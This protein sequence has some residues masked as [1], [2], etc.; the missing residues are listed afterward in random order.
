MRRIAPV[1]V[2][3]A[4]FYAVL[5][6]LRLDQHGAIW[7]AH[8]GDEFLHSA[9]TSHAIDSVHR[10]ESP[11]GYDGQFYFFIA[12]D[13][14]HAHDYMRVGTED[15]SGIRYARVAYPA[16]ARLASA[17]SM[18]VLPAVMIALNLLAVGLGTAAVALWLVRRGRTPWPAALYGLW[19]G[20][21]YAVFRDLSEPLAYCF[22]ALALLVFD[23]R[24]NRRLAGAAGFLALSLLT[25]ETT[26]A[27]VVGL[28]AAIALHDRSW[29]RPLAFF[30][31]AIAPMIAWR[32]A[33]TAWLHVTT[34]ESAHSGLKILLPFYGMYSR[35]PFDVQHK[36]IFYSVDLPLV[37]A[38]A[39]AL[40]LVYRRRELGLALLT[41]L[42][43]ALFVVFLPKNVT[44]D[45]GAVVR[46]A[47][48]ALLAALYLVP[49]IRSR[50][51]LAAGAF[52]LSPVWY[53]IVA[54]WLGVR[55]LRFATT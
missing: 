55:G 18:T 34:I 22:A 21:V 32:L 53:L 14:S 10:T 8:I 29:R 40:Y 1:L 20:V 49:A 19:P 39:G 51:V 16:A 5:V 6:P 27:F 38:G 15:Q 48:P 28:T 36:L 2:A 26:I 7:F 30:A 45:W 17:G 50:L 46:N 42:N 37:L 35:Y 47:T 23:P 43:V 31:G 24:S 4:V 13:P 41:V 52:F 44:I 33:V 12:A 9:H 25:R 54:A 11:F 3:V